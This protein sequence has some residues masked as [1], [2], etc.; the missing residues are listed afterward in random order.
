VLCSIFGNA[1]HVTRFEQI[2]SLPKMKKNVY[3]ATLWNN[4]ETTGVPITLHRLRFSGV[5][6]IKRCS[7][8]IPRCESYFFSSAN[9]NIST[10][11]S[12]TAPASASLGFHY[13]S[14]WSISVSCQDDVLSRLWDGKETKQMRNL[15][16]I[17]G[18][19]S[20][21]WREIYLVPPFRAIQLRNIPGNEPQNPVSPEI[22]KV[23]RTDR[24]AS[25]FPLFSLADS[26]RPTRLLPSLPHSSLSFS[27]AFPLVSAL[28][29]LVALTFRITMR[30]SV[31]GI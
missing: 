22:S 23:R 3:V 12:I 8:I 11:T 18:R 13:G 19:E 1:P 31:C 29:S 26:P 16:G 30:I 25:S 2:I 15:L 20:W 5:A 4:F 6:L 17:N 9:I 14:P 7:L 28:F 21:K 27:P 10:S 24:R